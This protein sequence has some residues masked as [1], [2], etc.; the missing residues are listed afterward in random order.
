MEQKQQQALA[1]AEDRSGQEIVRAAEQAAN[2]IA[3]LEDRLKKKAPEFPLTRPEGI[4]EPIYNALRNYLGNRIPAG[5]F[6]MAVLHNNLHEA[7]AR[8][9]AGSLEALPVI[10]HFVYWS[11]PGIAWGS[12][13]RVADWLKKS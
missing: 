4:P 3:G 6:V 13:E 12:P 11:V 1:I 8:A 2:Y 7:L 10:C 9:D 5:R